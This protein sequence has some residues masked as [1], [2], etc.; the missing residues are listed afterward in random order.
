MKKEPSQDSDI[1]P[2]YDFSGGVRGKY[3]AELALGSSVAYTVPTDWITK[4]AM[5]SSISRD[6]CADALIV[7]SNISSVLSTRLPDISLDQFSTLTSRISADALG[8]NRLVASAD[9][10][11]RFDTIASSLLAQPTTLAS[12]LRMPSAVAATT[13]Y[14][15][16]ASAL[17]SAARVDTHHLAGL[18]LNTMGALRI[19]GSQLPFFGQQGVTALGSVNE[20]LGIAGHLEVRINSVSNL[21]NT[22][23]AASRITSEALSFTTTPDIRD[24]IAVTTADLSRLSSIGASVYAEIAMSR[25]V[26]PTSFLFSAPAIEP[27]AQIQATSM[28]VGVD[29]KRREAQSEPSADETLDALGDELEERLSRVNADLANAY[30]EGLAAIRASQRG[31]IRHAGVSFRTMFDHLLRQL[32]PD[33]ALNEFLDNPDAYKQDGEYQRAARLTYIFRDVAVGS[34]AR[35]AEHDIKLAQ[36]TFFPANEIV[37]QLKTPLTE[38]QMEVLFRRIQG[39]VSVVLAAAGY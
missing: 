13:S 20:L 7:S 18:D 36:A 24:Y 25:R 17:A 26:E 37:H 9:A 15:D 27:Y 32:A 8:I 19:Q 31:W 22:T 16:A 34:Y 1:R 5:I 14:L 3:A 35:M 12:Y 11:G 21:I 38:R 39:S 29:D 23:L 30:L 4:S 6:L 33:E 2:E 10:I 28:M